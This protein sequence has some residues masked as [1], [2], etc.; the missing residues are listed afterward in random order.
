MK[1]IAKLASIVLTVLGVFTLYM[2]YKINILPIKYFLIVSGIILVIILFLDV[3][4]IQKKTKVFN[5][6]FFI[7]I[8][9]GCSVGIG[10]ILSYLNSTYDFMNSLAIK[11]YEVVT[12]DVITKTGNNID[13]INK[14]ENKTIS[15]LEDDKNY[16]KVKLLVK[17]DIKYEDRKVFD[18]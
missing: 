4:L 13:S 3:K 2:V 8:S 5:R 11:D 18:N 6:L 14:L 7:I 17:K 10:F 16:E 12:Y 1:F 15:Y 9:I